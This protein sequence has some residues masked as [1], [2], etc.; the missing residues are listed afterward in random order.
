MLLAARWHAK[1]LYSAFLAATEAATQGQD[2]LLGKLLARNA[3]SAYGV[4]HGFRRIRTYADFTRQVPIQEYEDL[5]PYIERVKRGELGALFGS[6][7]KVLMFAMSSGTS[8]RPKYIPVTDDFLRQVRRGWNVFGVKT[9]LD[10]P[11]SL[12]RPM[13]QVV[14]PMDEARTEAGIP[15]GAITGLTAA[16][17]RRLVRKYYIC[18]RCVAY[19]SCPTARYYTIMR[20]AIPR[21]VAF[22]ITAS[23]ATILKLVRTAD[24]QR[25]QMVRDIHDGTISAKLEVADDIRATLGGTLRPEPQSARRLEGL[26]AE[27]GALLPKH[28]WNL[29]FLANWTGGT[30]GLYLQHYPH[31]FGDVPVRDV[32]LLASEG[33]MSIPIEDHTPA[34]LL[35]VTGGFYEFIPAGEI[36]AGRPVVLRSHELEV[37]GEYFILLTNSAGLYR[38]NIGDVV[39]VVGYRGQAPIIEFLN[40]GAHISSL[41]GEKL[42]E[43]QVVQSVET[44]CQQHG[45]RMDS[46]VLAPQ[47]DDPP[48]YLLHLEENGRAGW[49]ET[50]LA[51]WLEAEL[52]RRNCEYESKR[53]TGRLGPVRINTLPPGTLA[54]QDAALRTRFREH[55]NEQY[56]HQF[57]YTQPGQDADLRPA[58]REPA[59]VPAID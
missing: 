14:S 53:K 54:R 20:L 32:G 5:A 18:P 13:V 21:D 49:N 7:Q 19:I 16:T 52:C 35:E 50:S 6:G 57:L 3:D 26:I 48:Y 23:P 25:E 15:C 39:G 40:K 1:R 22:L 34:G 45:V 51:D 2:V 33:R 30:M 29:C 17:Q 41:S 36:D 10:H 28:Y 43:R 59:S 55:A 24:Q 9:L 47:W 46:F 12:L 37:G 31:Y 44:V 56:K 8:D 4:D 42:T 58:G 11:G 38:Y 27:H